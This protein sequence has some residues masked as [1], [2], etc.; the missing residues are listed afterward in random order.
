M[1]PFPSCLVTRKEK[2]LEIL[3][4][5]TVSLGAVACAFSVY[6][7][8]ISSIDFTFPIFTM[9]AIAVTTFLQIQL[10]RTKMHFTISDSVIFVALMLYGG[11]VG[12]LIAVIESIY[13]SLKLKR[14]GVTI[15]PR[16][17]M[18]NCAIAAIATQTTVLVTRGVFGSIQ[19]VVDSSTPA[20]FV[21]MMSVMVATQFMVNSLFVAAFAAIRSDKPIWK[22][23]YEYCLNA[24]LMFLTGGF[25]AAVVVKALHNLEPVLIVIAFV[26]AVVVFLTYK[27]YIEELKLTAD[28]AET[29]ERQRAEQAERHI[30]ELQHYIRE[31]E[32]TSEEL[33]ESRER[34]RHAAFH[35]GLTNLPN[36]NLFIETLKFL[37][38][39][40]KRTPNRAFAVLSLDL[41]RFKTINESL[42]HSV[43][44][45]LISH[46]AK[47]LSSLVREN[48]LVGRFSGDSF[49]I[50]LN[51]IQMADDAVQFAELIQRR[52]QKPFTIAGRQVFTTASI[53]ISICNS[54]YEEAEDILRDADIA[55]YHAKEGMKECIVFDQSMHTRAVTLLQLETDLRSAI[56]RNELSVYYQPIVDLATMKLIGFEALMRWNHPQ[57]GIIPPNEFIPVAEETGLIVPMT[58]WILE[59]SCSQMVEWQ[60][61]DPENESLM[62]SV[63]LSGKHFAHSDIVEQIRRVIVETTIK[64]SSVKLE[65][66]ESAVME[67]AETAIAMLKNLRS[68]GLQL[69]IDDFGTGYSSLSY[70]HRFPIDM[71]KVDRSFVGSMEDGTENG[72]IVRTVIALGKTL[73]LSIVAEGIETIHQLHQLRILGC[74]YGQGYLF[75][76]PVPVDEATAVLDDKTRWQ[77]IIPD[78]NPAVVAQ[79]REFSRLRLAK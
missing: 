65:I 38:E 66:T 11:E 13:T 45:R 15:M 43:G 6:N 35:D 8:P 68:L 76:R 58:L 63:N 74:E 47:R 37:L 40:Y 12:I 46:V 44:D 72:E 25:L 71:L 79:N 19:T 3:L 41:N 57:R 14:K 21:T 54:N 59:K 78:N 31:Q 5:T 75:S 70:L 20:E 51:N 22:V 18:L 23:W 36:R 42:G 60:K 26:V 50:I 61:R 52:I 29:S 73:G 34:Y 77:N 4:W 53:G 32:R 49:G 56:D 17:L 24:L 39:K 33:R 48:D 28:Q 2:I 62:I 30:E 1:R 7:L 69:S 10:P 27:R 9:G 55:M 16:T 67:N 64:P